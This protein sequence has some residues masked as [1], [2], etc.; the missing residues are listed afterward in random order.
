MR[1]T[2]IWMAEDITLLSAATYTDPYREAGISGTFVSPTGKTMVL[3]GFWDGENRFTVRFAPNEPGLW[4]Y[5]V[6]M[7]D[8]SAR[9]EG[10]LLAEAY[11]GD[12]PLYAH[13]FLKAVPGKR[14]LEHDDGT[15]FF[16]L[17]DTHWLG[18]GGRERFCESNSP[19]FKTMFH[20]MADVRKMEEFT[21]YQMNFFVTA[22]G[23]CSG[24]GTSNEGGSL[25][26]DQPFGTMNPGFFQ[27]ADQRIGYL[28]SIGITPCLGM[29][30]GPG[31][32][33]E[34]LEEFKRIT[35]YIIARY[36]AFPVVWFV[37]GEYA[38][39]SEYLLWDQIGDLFEEK[40]AYAHVTTIHGNGENFIDDP[41]QNPHNADLFREKKWYD[42]V[43]LQT[44]HLPTLP[45][46]NNWRYYYDKT[47]VKPVLEA[48]N[49]YEGIWE[50]REPLT[51]E[52]AYVAIM[53]GSFGVTYGAEGVWDA[54]WDNN[55]RH[56]VVPPWWPVP[57]YDAI[58]LPQARQLT[59][60]KH[61]MESVHW[62]NLEPCEDIRLS[63]PL[64]SMRDVAAK[65][66]KQKDEILVYYPNK[67]KGYDTAV[68]LTAMPEKAVYGVTWV[69]PETGA[70]VPGEN[71][72]VQENGEMP[73]PPCSSCGRDRLLIL[74]KL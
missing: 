73:L 23:D 51:R 33:S 40:D 63:N 59:T 22:R 48:E 11:T 26:L 55:D 41:E 70:F 2:S 46:R 27:N 9:E 10:Q 1:K 52:Q 32:K 58:L 36:S 50:V 28:C 31:I 69:N 16:W 61:A 5:T 20:G 13:G 60:L 68:T 54:T 21:V 45:K 64:N 71:V 12:N 43:M 44:G 66:D 57:W 14:Y 49:A 8:G 47:P 65:A 6:A 25:W 7:A 15:P 39:N 35:S 30:W 3:D 74:R 37:C 29:D 72:A 24:T 34:T 19:L 38:G 67:E 4:S 18:L 53:H 42:F 62:W 17:G 56:Q